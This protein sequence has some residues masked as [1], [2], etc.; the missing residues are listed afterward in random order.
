MKSGDTVS[1]YRIQSPLGSGGMGVVY[2]AEDLSLGR[3]VALKFL[4]GEF[5]RDG[6]AIE[7]F[8]REARAASALNHPNICTIYEIS[9]HE[10]QPFIAMEWIE[11]V[12]L[13]ERL[14]RSR[15]SMD[16][17]VTLAIDI[18]DALDAAHRADVVHRDIKPGNIFVTTRGRAKL[19]DFGLAKLDAGTHARS[20]APTGDEE[21]LTQTGAT[22]GTVSY[23]SPEQARGDS[24]DAR[25]DLFSFGVMLYEMATAV[26]PFTGSSNAVIFHEIL[27]KT[28]ASPQRLNPDVPPE[29]DRVIT[30]ALEKNRDVRCQSAAEMLSDLKRLKRDRDSSASEPSFK[31]LAAGAPISAS[32]DTLMVAS[33]V[34]R[35]HFGLAFIAVALALA[36]AGAAYLA[37]RQSG[38]SPASSAASFGD[39][40]I[41]RLTSSGNARSPAISPDGKYVAYVQR[42]GDNDSLWIRQ[43]AT[44]SNTR[45]VS[46][47]PGV[48][49][50][51]VT[52]TPDSTFVDFVR[53]GRQ[54]ELA[55]FSLWRVSFLGGTPRRLIDDVHSA[56]G[57]SPDGRQMAFIRSPGTSDSLV[58]ADA[59]GRS[60]RVLVTQ[61]SPGPRFSTVLYPGNPSST[62]A[63]SPDSRVIAAGGIDFSKGLVE[64]VFFV[65]VSDRSISAAPSPAGSGGVAWMDDSSLIVT[66]RTESLNQLWRLSYPGGQLSRV[67]N[68]LSTYSGVSL[69][70]DRGALVT[71]RTEV[72]GSI[73]T[74]DAAASSGKDTI[75]PV[76]AAFTTGQAIAWAADRL[77]FTTAQQALYALPPGGGAPE[78][79]VSKARY[80]RA[81]S[82]GATVV[83]V[84]AEPGADGT[85]WKLDT[86][87][88]RATP[89]ASGNNSY[90]VITPDDQ[91]V[92]FMSN[93]G[94]RGGALSLVPLAGGTPTRPFEISTNGVNV[95]PDGKLLA[96]AGSYQ[97]RRSLMLCDW[98]ACVTRRPLA[99]L[100]AVSDIRWMP[101]GRSVAYA[102]RQAGANIWVQPLDK[103]KPHQLTHFTDGRLLLDFA[104]SRDGTRL[105]IVRATISSDIVLVKGLKPKL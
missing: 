41:E 59:D 89:L 53:R 33:V 63:W 91:D 4:H 66:R 75:Q 79:I 5:A 72:Q 82:D 86:N 37:N 21:R 20:S 77:I 97:N 11:G 58:I 27:S 6:T 69:T 93:P 94:V 43:T 30:K 54:G 13:K 92:I 73:W 24:L 74:G 48:A 51:A 60:E 61:Q 104:W 96:F 31:T 32:S 8:R 18:A 99:P 28:P 83:Y 29:L 25:T 85:L 34:K 67:T 100:E 46:P 103:S 1:H 52:F 3:K 36:L 44:T 9:E 84:S 45:I 2:L 50:A 56:V 14:G 19:L 78:L 49:L 102:P 98:P 101:D 81:T 42:D 71:G 12:S 47:Q 22:L 95:S 64:K 17:L 16:E 80:P 35:H 57:W 7:R 76:A 15:L 70:A 26:A 105:A 40:E 62:P 23:M 39:L 55:V 88:G 68:D 87:S 38:S 65:N 90:P 10:G